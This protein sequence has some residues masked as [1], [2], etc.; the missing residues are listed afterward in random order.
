MEKNLSEAV[1]LFIKT[2]EKINGGS[3]QS[4]KRFFLEIKMS[5]IDPLSQTKGPLGSLRI[6]SVGQLSKGRNRSYVE[7]IC[8]CVFF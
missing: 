8:G 6:W 7:K 2:S 5:L 1:Q 4:H 3:I